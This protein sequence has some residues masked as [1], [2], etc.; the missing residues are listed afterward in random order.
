MSIVA[1]S[2]LELASKPRRVTRKPWNGLWGVA[3]ALL[4]VACGGSVPALKAGPMPDGGDFTGVWFSQQYG[5]MHMIQ[6]GSSVHGRYEL[7]QR[8]GKINGDANG[9]L[10]RFEWEEQK[11]MVSN[12]P[13]ITK[14][15]GYFRYTVNADTGEHRIEGRWG[16]DADDRNGGDWTAYKMRNREP[17]LPTET[18]GD[19]TGDDPS[20]VEVSDDD[21]F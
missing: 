12:R 5:E 9:D 2:A 15:H 4:L 20:E 13:N 8:T 18:S 6:E 11:S 19:D 7:D 1:V 17:E 10:L 3:A 16:L 14:G 21:L